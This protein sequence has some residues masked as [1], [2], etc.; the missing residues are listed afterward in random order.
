MP[1][2]TSALSCAVFCVALV[3]VASPAAS[4][5]H[6]KATATPASEA[7]EPLPGNGPLYAKLFDFQP[8]V[9]GEVPRGTRPASLPLLY[10]SFIGLEAYD[11]YSTSTGTVH[12][13]TESNPLLRGAVGNPVVLW[14]IKGAAAFTSI[15]ISERLWR[16]HRRAQAVA[17]MVISNAVMAAVAARNLS[18]LRGRP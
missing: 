5:D 11:G 4:Q 18:V 14:T 10:A 1:R 12:G 17:V 16:H 6:S 3:V 13:A 8:F 15:Y 9:L 2:V 7:G